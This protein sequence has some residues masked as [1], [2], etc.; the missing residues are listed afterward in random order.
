MFV[1]IVRTSATPVGLNPDHLLDAL[2]PFG[3]GDA[4]GTFVTDRITAVQARLQI[5]PESR[6]EQLPYVDPDT[7]C[8]VL[9]WARLDNRLDLAGRRS[10]QVG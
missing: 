6:R 3:S 10:C 4:Q 8:V 2:C 5:T 9:S 1:G 7:G